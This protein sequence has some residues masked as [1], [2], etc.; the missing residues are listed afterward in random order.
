V[1]KTLKALRGFLGLTG[2]Y[3]K[4]IKGY[5]TLAAPL[6]ALTKKHAFIWTEA[7]Q[8]AFETLKKT[9][10]NPP[11][12]ALPNYSSPFVIECDASASRIG[13]ILMQDNHPI[14]YISQELKKS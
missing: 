10:T 8:M 6:T 5:S 12:L 11:V 14:A 13:A 7:T 2:Y 9:L 1:P 4:F 3:R